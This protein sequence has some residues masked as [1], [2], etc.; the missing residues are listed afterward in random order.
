M[1]R[2][3]KSKEAKDLALTRKGIEG[4]RR[5]TTD[6]LIQ[7]EHAIKQSNRFIIQLLIA[8]TQT[9]I[10]SQSMLREAMNSW[11]SMRDELTN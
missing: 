5:A 11:T 10:V 3:L 9:A 7:W 4:Q 6:A 2:S 8:N 1:R